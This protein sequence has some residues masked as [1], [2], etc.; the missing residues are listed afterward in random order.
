[1]AG[2]SLAAASDKVIQMAGGHNSGGGA[3]NVTW[4]TSTRSPLL[5]LML[6]TV[7]VAAGP[8]AGRAQVSD[9]RSDTWVAVDGL[10]RRVQGYAECGP[11]RTDRRVGIFY[12]LWHGVYG[13]AGPFNISQILAANPEAIN[14]P[15]NPAWGPVNAFHHWNQ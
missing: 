2:Q 13:Q 3:A 1:M 10:G 6:A 5:R 8:R 4:G 12:H 11:A 9:L 14:E 7:C 15:D